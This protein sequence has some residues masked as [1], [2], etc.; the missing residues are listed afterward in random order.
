MRQILPDVYVMEGLGVNVYLLV[1]SSGLTLVDSGV[2]R[3]VD[4]IISQLQEAGFALSG[5]NE[6]ILTHWHGDH[7][8]GAEAL[9]RRSCS[10][11]LAHKDETPSIERTASI[12]SAHLIQRMLNWLAENILLK[13]ASCKVDRQLEDGD[14]IEALGGIKV[15]HTP[16]HTPG[17]ICLYHPERKIL[18]CGDALF[19]VHP[20]TGRRGLGL[21]MKLLALDNERARVSAR[22]LSTLDVQVLCCGHGDPVLDGA[23]EKMRKLLEPQTVGGDQESRDRTGS[24]GA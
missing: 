3:K 1:S 10:R 13:R 17:S 12:P 24:R 15:I 20:I 19:N 8:G 4:G 7:A 18:F 14:V 22:R 21:H 2:A 11:V 5:L 16:G 9:A 23:S 6:I